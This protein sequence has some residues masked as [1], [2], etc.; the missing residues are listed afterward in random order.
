MTLKRRVERRKEPD[1]R[2]D[3][4]GL[5]GSPNPESADEARLDRMLDSLVQPPPS[6]ALKR[7]VL[8]LG[9]GRPDA[10]PSRT[11]GATPRLP[12]WRRGASLPLAMAA[13]LSVLAVGGSLGPF[14]RDTSGTPVATHGEEDTARPALASHPAEVWTSDL[15]VDWGLDV[16][17]TFVDRRPDSVRLVDP[18][19]PADD[20]APDRRIA[21][22]GVPLF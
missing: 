16:P 8:A 9:E 13:A 17:G 21:A 3:L 10:V 1:R 18:A 20:A 7:R 19:I 6:P 12:V 15:A 4:A 11:T 2:M 5:E 14:V 22:I